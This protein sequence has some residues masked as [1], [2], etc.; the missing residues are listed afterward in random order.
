M[1][2]PQENTLSAFLDHIIWIINIDASDKKSSKETIHHIWMNYCSFYTKK[3][4]VDEE[5]FLKK[6]AV[7]NA[8]HEKIERCYEENTCDTETLLAIKSLLMN[9]ER[10]KFNQINGITDKCECK[11]FVVKMLCGD[12][13]KTMKF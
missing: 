1:Q 9:Y 12:C 3:I 4:N 6:H 13:Y 7:M 2:E 11:G 10:Y 8:I 5:G